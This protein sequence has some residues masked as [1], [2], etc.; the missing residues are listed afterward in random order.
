MNYLSLIAGVQEMAQNELPI[1]GQGAEAT[2]LTLNFVD[3]A[4]KEAG[5]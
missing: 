4:F 2:E 1:E 5:S 3:L